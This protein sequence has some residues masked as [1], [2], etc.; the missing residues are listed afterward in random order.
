MHDI[1]S[2]DSHFEPGLI[3]PDGRLSRLHKGAKKP[4]P[5][6]P[7]PAPSQTE[8]EPEREAAILAGRRKGLQSTILGDE[9]QTP[10]LGGRG[11]LG[12]PNRMSGMAYGG[13]N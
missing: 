4:K 7:A 9:F 1:Y 6:P 11:T 2:F 12:K 8:Q 5:P 3:G 10:T 13:E